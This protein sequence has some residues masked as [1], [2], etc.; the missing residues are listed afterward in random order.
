MCGSSGIG[1]SGR[2]VNTRFCVVSV[3]SHF[4][5][6][7]LNT[8][9]FGVL[10]YVCLHRIFL[11]LCCCWFNCFQINFFFVVVFHSDFL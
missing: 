11:A 2:F 4:R 9:V 6:H 5:M 1:F 10:I 3:H 8:L 7:T